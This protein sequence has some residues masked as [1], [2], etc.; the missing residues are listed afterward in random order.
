MS[1][2]RLLSFKRVVKGGLRGFVELELSNGL[3][4]SDIALLVGSSGAWAS[5]PQKPQIAGDGTVRRD[6]NGKSISTAIMRWRDRARA[7]QFSQ[8]V[9]DLVLAEHPGALGDGGAP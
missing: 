5:L 6:A 7:D 9:I 1:A 8:A 2:M 3:I 4:I